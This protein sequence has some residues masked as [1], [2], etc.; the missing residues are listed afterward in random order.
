MDRDSILK[1][2]ERQPLDDE[3]SDKI[4]GDPIES[5]ITAILKLLGENPDRAGLKKTPERVAKSLRYLTSG[6]QESLD[7]LVNGALF[8]SSMEEMI[9][10]KDIEFYSLC[11]HHLLPF[12]GHCHIAY[13]PN[14]KIMG[15]S[16]IPRL[17]DFY[18]RR[19]QIQEKLTGQ[20]ADALM[21]LLNAK[22]VAIIMEAQHLCMRMRGVEKQKASLK[23]SVMRGLFRDDLRMRSQ[24]F[25]LL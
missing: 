4:Q 1:V 11:E 13:I 6:K 16:K 2:A 12:M 23:T 18:A 7:T 8:D 22:G 25:S 20:I 10:V 5:H 24:F 9:L 19:L 15:L 3:K 17:L 21:E 14:G